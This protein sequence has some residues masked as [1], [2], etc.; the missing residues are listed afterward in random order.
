[1][2]TVSCRKLSLFYYFE[3]TDTDLKTKFL[4]HQQLLVIRNTVMHSGNYSVTDDER[5]AYCRSIEEMIERVLKFPLEPTEEVIYLN[6]KMVNNIFM[7]FVY[8]L[9]IF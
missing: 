9:R 8:M 2:L 7:N 4:Y 1:M 6:I 3:N 5:K